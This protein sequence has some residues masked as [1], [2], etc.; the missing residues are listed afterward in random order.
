MIFNS[1][2]NECLPIFMNRIFPEWASVIL[3]VSMVLIVG[4]ILP[5]ILFSGPRK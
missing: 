1:F 5:S 3:S 4:E 2:A